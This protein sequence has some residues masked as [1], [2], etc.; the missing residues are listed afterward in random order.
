MLSYYIR[1]VPDECAFL[2]AGWLVNMMNA[3]TDWWEFLY[4]RAARNA[5]FN[6]FGG[7]VSEFRSCQAITTVTF[8]ISMLTDTIANLTL[9]TAIN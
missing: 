6:D 7:G 9:S 8:R 4:I 1:Q 5:H 2:T 3:C